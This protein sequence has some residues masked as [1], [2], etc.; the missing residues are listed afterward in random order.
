MADLRVDLKNMMHIYY[1]IYMES[2]RMALMNLFAGQQWRCRHREQTCGHRGEG[3]D[4][5]NSKS[6][7]ETYT[8]PHVK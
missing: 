5:T 6:S 1:W 4:G 2:K 8:S 3:E 7:I